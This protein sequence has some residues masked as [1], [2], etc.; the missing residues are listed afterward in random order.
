[1]AKAAEQAADCAAENRVANIAFNIP[2][3]DT[4]EIELSKLHGNALCYPESLEIPQTIAEQE[5][6]M[7]ELLENGKEVAIYQAI[8]ADPRN[9][10]E[11]GKFPSLANLEIPGLDAVEQQQGEFKLLMKSAPQDNPQFLAIQLQ[12]QKAE[13]DPEAQTPQGQQMVQQ[14][15]QALQS[16]PPKV[17]SVPVAQN[18]SEN[19]ALHAEITLGFM[20]SPAGRKLKN[21]DPEQKQIFQNLSLHWSE[22]VQMGEKLT[23]PKE[24]E[25]KGSLTVDPS[26]FSPEV[27]SKVFQAAGLQVSPEEASGDNQLVPHEVT[28][29]KEGV[30]AQGVPVKQ[31]IA[32]MNPGGK[33][34]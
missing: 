23:P 19:H 25:F 12:I 3:Q 11:F 22:H 28:T 8:A 30:D 16:I 27:Q 14:L 33:L 9:L 5:A 29:E 24:M 21:G 4:L 2:G 34:R 32:M 17:S 15:Q 18:G 7:A 13:T 20:T 26:K 10:V 1:L 6:Q 31:K